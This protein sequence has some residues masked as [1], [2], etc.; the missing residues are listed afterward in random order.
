MDGREGGRD[1][2]KQRAERALPKPPTATEEEGRSQ[3]KTRQG[4]RGQEREG[5]PGIIKPKTCGG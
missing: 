2:E 4:Q 3:D 1:K 5:D